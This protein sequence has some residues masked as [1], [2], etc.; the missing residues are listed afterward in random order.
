MLLQ[1]H[2][3]AVLHVTNRGELLCEVVK[4]ARRSGFDLA[5]AIAVYDHPTRPTE[6]VVVDNT[7]QGYLEL[8]N[9]PERYRKDPVAQYCKRSSLPLVWN[10]STY[11]AAGQGSLW[12]E[13]AVFG[14]RA[15]V[16]M[17]LHL[18]NGR[19]FFLG[20]DRDRSLTSNADELTRV[21]AD[22]TVF[23]TYAQEAA[24]RVLLPTISRRAPL[25]NELVLG[26]SA[27]AKDDAS[28]LAL[29]GSPEAKAVLPA[30]ALV[31]RLD[32]NEKHFFGKL[33]RRFDLKH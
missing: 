26:L 25:S 16:A 3:E 11:V 1:D 29:C 7:P 28:Q 24:A 14:Y 19:H 20:V 10:Q 9:S 22:F 12:E 27:S 23:L 31:E 4:F 6:F 30:A 8:S 18:P 33:F 21:V 13:Q 5:S 15:G 17:A 2:C 32:R